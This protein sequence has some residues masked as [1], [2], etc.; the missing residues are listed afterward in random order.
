MEKINEKE[1]FQD[2][3]EKQQEKDKQIKKM[4]D[5]ELQIKQ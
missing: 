4:K 1:H 5:E 3:L 2:Y